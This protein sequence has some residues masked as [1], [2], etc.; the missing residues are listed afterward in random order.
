MA[1]RSAALPAVETR[2]AHPDPQPDPPTASTPAATV[3]LMPI[4]AL[5]RFRHLMR[6]EGWDVDLQRM[7]VD[8]SYAFECLATGHCSGDARLRETALALFGAYHR[9]AAE[10]ALH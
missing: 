1:P 2:M 9:N 4:P 10:P 5:A 7:C 8:D 3:L 6:A